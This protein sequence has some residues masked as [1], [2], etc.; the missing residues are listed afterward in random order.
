MVLMAPLLAGLIAAST[1]P[2]DEKPPPACVGVEFVPFET[3][4]ARLTPLAREILGHFGVFLQT[5]LARSKF[6]SRLEVTGHT[7]SVGRREF[8]LRLSRRRAEVVRNYLAAKGF[9]RNRIVIEAA[10]EDKPIVDTPDET[11]ER[12]NRYVYLFEHLSPEELVHR[13]T[14]WAR[15]GGPNVVC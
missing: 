9:P 12:Q 3:G 7:D 15:L 5:S 2:A 13:E 4:S 1:T 8:N 10:G 6:S 14:I 11:A